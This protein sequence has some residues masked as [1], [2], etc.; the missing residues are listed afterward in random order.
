MAETT[1]STPTKGPTGAG[2]GAPPPASDAAPPER[3]DRVTA[4]SNLALGGLL[5]AID[6]L[7]EWVDRNVPGQ[8][9][10]LEELQKQ[11]GALLPQAEWEATFGRPAAAIGLAVT[12]N[13]QAVRATRFVL[14][15][16]GLAVDAARWPLDH[17]WLLSP[18][19]S[20]I[21][22]LADAGTRR[23]DGLVQVGR[24]TEAG[25]RAVAQVS[26]TKAANDSVDLMTV[27]PHVQV[28]IQEIIT[29]QGTSITQAIIRELREHSVSLDLQ[30][31][32]GW[33][34]LRGRPS[35]EIQM[36]DFTVSL[37]G[38]KPTTQEMAGRPYLG[39][40]YAGF[41]SRLLAFCIDI[42]VI[43][44]ALVV[45]YVFVRAI[46]SIFSVDRWLQALLGPDGFSTL[47]VAGSGVLGTLVAI[48][49]WIFGWTFIGSTLGK[50]LMGLLVVGPGG[51]R[52]GFWRS[53]RR[54]VGYFISILAVGL[55]FLWV[56]I[57]KQH[58]DWP[59]KLAGTSVVYVWHARP[60]ETF[61]VAS[62]PAET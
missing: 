58:R 34:R 52:V 42:F 47:R 38:Q 27:E 43:I 39:G 62:P 40:A 45:G 14:R 29:A 20:G 5:T 17:I 37:Q 32:R 18:L 31:D 23:V 26:M 48:V 41:V 9:Q 49:Y 10:A 61:L 30:V 13:A 24:E 51:S 36:P 54:V 57:N 50:V 22:R 56:I 4:Y 53:L 11:Q 8:A 46:V 15:A 44:A 3:P 25:S 6:A 1:S 55:G 59:D 2:S 28:L 60:D 33:A 21:D 12:A 16:G 7:D 35:P 19:R